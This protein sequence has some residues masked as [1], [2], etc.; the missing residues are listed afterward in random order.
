MARMLKLRLRTHTQSRPQSYRIPDRVGAEHGHGLVWRQAIVCDQRRTQGRGLASHLCEVEMFVC[1]CIAI[2][3]QV[4][5]EGSGEGNV[6]LALEEPF[7]G[8][9]IGWN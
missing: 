2:T 8:R 7:P 4:I 3:P 1:G 6:A 9:H 5:L